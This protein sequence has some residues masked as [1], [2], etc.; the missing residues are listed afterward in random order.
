MTPV[1]CDSLVGT[2]GMFGFC[3]SDRS[4]RNFFMNSCCLAG[5]MF[6]RE[7]GLATLAGFVTGVADFEPGA[8]SLGD[9]P[10]AGFVIVSFRRLFGSGVGVE[11]PVCRLGPGIVGFLTIGEGDL[12]YTNL[13]GES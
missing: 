5:N 7:R 3:I 12:Q 8:G 11:G 2:V 13:F 4:L 6:A 1:G 9:A 10:D